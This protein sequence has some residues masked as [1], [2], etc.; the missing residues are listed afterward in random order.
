MSHDPFN[1][2]PNLTA[3]ITSR[4]AQFFRWN[5]AKTPAG[6]SHVHFLFWKNIE[7]YSQDKYFF[8]FLMSYFTISE[9]QFPANYLLNF[10]SIGSIFVGLVQLFFI[11]YLWV[12]YPISALY[13]FFV[14]S[15]FGQK[16]SFN[17]LSIN[18]SFVFFLF[19]WFWLKSSLRVQIFI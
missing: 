15:S 13:D 16:K 17:M 18:A 4:S 10:R 2:W 1:E 9:I 7:I 19:L 8:D 6:K 11:T 12:H 14:F 5:W 3:T